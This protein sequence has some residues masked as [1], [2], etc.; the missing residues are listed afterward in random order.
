MVGIGGSYILFSKAIDV[1][2]QVIDIIKSAQVQFSDPKV[3]M[4]Y[5]NLKLKA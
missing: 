2:I 1:I 3:N 5:Y 4:K